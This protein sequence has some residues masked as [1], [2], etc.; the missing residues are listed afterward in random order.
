MLLRILLLTVL[1]MGSGCFAGSAADLEGAGADSGGG[2]GG[3]VSEPGG[4]PDDGAAA[5]CQVAADC[6]LAAS[7]CCECPSFAVPAGSG[8]D[9]GCED[10]EC[11][12]DG[13]CSAVEAACDGGQCVMICSPIITDKTCEFGFATDDSGCLLDECAG[14]SPNRS[15]ECEIDTDCVEVPADCCGCGRGGADTAVPSGEA[16]SFSDGLGCPADASCPEIDVCDPTELP[17]CVGG[18]CTLAPADGST[19]PLDGSEPV[20]LCGTPE[21]APCEAGT[22]C[23]LN[24]NSPNNGSELG[25]GRC[26]P[27]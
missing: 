27:E 16:D 3:A 9:S 22:I 19:P 21:L 20:V 10:V 5:E 14:A 12:P 15:A 7:S 1:A 11:V 26:V 25:V 2:G 13:V 18:S 17:R 8:F 24:A 6:V 4:D 23:V